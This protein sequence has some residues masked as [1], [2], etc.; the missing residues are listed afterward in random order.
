MRNP[1]GSYGGACGQ[2]QGLARAGWVAGMPSLVPLSQEALGAE[3]RQEEPTDWD[4]HLGHMAGW[5][6]MG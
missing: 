4:K 6:G 2:L 1:Q 3:P 5:A